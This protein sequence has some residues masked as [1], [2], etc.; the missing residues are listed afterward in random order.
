MTTERMRRAVP[1][2]LAVALL[3]ALAVQAAPSNAP[4]TQARASEPGTGW[5]LPVRDG[6]QADLAAAPDG[7]LLLSWVEGEGDARRLRFA[8]ERGGRWS[9]PLTIATGDWFGNPVDTP[10]LRQTP[11]GALWATWMRKGPGGGHARDVVIARSADGG[12]SWSAPAPV[13]RDATATEHGFVSLWPVGRDRLGVAWLDGRAKAGAAHGEGAQMLRSATFDA[14]LR[15]QGEGAVDAKVCDCCHT[16]VALTPR[17]PL[18]VY[19][20][21][22][23]TEVRDIR[24]VHLA[25]V[26]PTPRDVHRDGW[27]MPGCP[28]NGPAVAAEGM[29]VATAWYTAAGGEP[30]VRM[31]LSGD[32][33]ERFA[34]PITLDRG[35]AVLGRV[36]VVV[37]GGRS[38]AAWLREDATSQSLWIASV[39]GSTR[40]P[41][42]QRIA[43]LAGRGRGTGMPRL[44]A[45]G[46]ALHLV[47]TDVVGG[48]PV[49]HGRRL[50]LR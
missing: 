20:D 15:A 35:T 12:R 48:R 23:D 37:Q 30:E 46:D 44:V 50:L 2:A 49:L 45:R 14:R 18:L 3:A 7:S 1:A 21:R 6:A 36:D 32:G 11:D 4:R 43:T 5:T 31:A 29:R 8:R 9:A 28:V 39:S 33:G 22:S 27:T 17:G 24:A 42:P 41:V 16:D 38:T 25:G 13:H 10:H 40:A 19:R 34:A 26:K 47:W